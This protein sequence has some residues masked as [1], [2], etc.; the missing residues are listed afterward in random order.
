MGLSWDIW[1]WLTGLENW[2]SGLELELDAALVWELILVLVWCCVTHEKE[3][4]SEIGDERIVDI[5]CGLVK[6]NS[7][8]HLF[9]QD[10]RC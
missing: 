7:F 2:W 6:V 10:D 4:C 8:F 3:K 1:Y 9:S 5:Y